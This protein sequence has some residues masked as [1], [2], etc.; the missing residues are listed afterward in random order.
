MGRRSTPER[1]NEARRA[2]NVRRLEGEGWSLDAAEAA[3]ARWEAESERQGLSRDS[4]DYRQRGRAWIAEQ[5][6]SWRQ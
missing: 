4:A 5:R 6:P 1:I 3:V 2:A